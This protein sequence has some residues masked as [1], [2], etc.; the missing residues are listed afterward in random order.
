[1]SDAD[2]EFGLAR[3][4]GMF[5]NGHGIHDRNRRGEHVVDQSFL[6]FFNAHF[7]PLVFC[8]P[9]ENFGTSWEIVIDTRVPDARISTAA[10]PTAAAVGEA[11]DAG[12]GAGPYTGHV[13]LLDTRATSRIVKAN[14]PIEVDARSALVLRCAD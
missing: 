3:S 14:D 2:W 12:P 5:L 1:M 11:G 7:E 6:L 10:V 4:L 13:G 9:A 8:V